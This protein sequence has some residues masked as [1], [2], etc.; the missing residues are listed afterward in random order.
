MPV[1]VVFKD[2]RVGSMTDFYIEPL[3]E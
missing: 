3:H 1:K 2:Q